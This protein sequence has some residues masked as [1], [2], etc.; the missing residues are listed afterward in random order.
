METAVQI[1]FVV[2]FGA[3]GLSHLVQPR[4]WARFFQAVHAKGEAGVFATAMLALMPGAIVV[5]F[6]NVWRGIP[7]VLT[8]IGWL[9]VLKATVY[10]LAPAVGA[11]T[12]ARVSPD[13][14]LGFRVAGVLMIAVGAL[15]AYDLGTTGSRAAPAPAPALRTAP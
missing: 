15:L 14:T 9:Y 4:A 5:G 1:T 13:R 10:L 11:K 6:H 2:C 8:V 7:V 12:L 3:I